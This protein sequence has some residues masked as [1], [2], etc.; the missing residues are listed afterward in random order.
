M[1]YF[2]LGSTLPPPFNILP[3]PKDVLRWL[4]IRKKDKLRRL[5]SKVIRFRFDDPAISCQC[6]SMYTLQV[7]IPSSLADCFD[8]S[9]I[10]AP[11]EPHTWTGLSL[12]GR[13]AGVGVALHHRHA[14]ATGTVWS[15]G[16]WRQRGQG[17]HL[18]AALRTA[19]SLQ[20]QRNG[21][22]VRQQEHQEYV[23]WCLLLIFFKNIWTKQNLRICL[24]KK[25]STS[26]LNICSCTGSQDEDLGAP[27]V[28]RLPRRVHGRWRRSGRSGPEHDRSQ[29]SGRSIPAIGHAG[30]Q[31]KRRQTS[32]RRRGHRF[33]PELEIFVSSTAVKQK[34][35]N[36]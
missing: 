5:S 16:R 6:N 7:P 36:H 3:T 12:R 35:K 20:K 14:P 19:R 30:R 8:C 4:G 33:R 32:A 17:R 27:F 1:S 28:T 9:P 26:N 31:S 18:H 21:H 29:W 23:T 25:I 34:E 22:L 15:D 10:A 13:H 24:N 11:P 2:E